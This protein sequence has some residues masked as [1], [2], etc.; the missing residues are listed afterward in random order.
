VLNRYRSDEAV[1]CHVEVT[2]PLPSN[3]PIL[4]LNHRRLALD[5]LEVETEVEPMMMMMMQPKNAAFLEEA[6]VHY[7][8]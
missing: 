3:H 6:E 7:H 8:R 4:F 5:W 2:L 1:V